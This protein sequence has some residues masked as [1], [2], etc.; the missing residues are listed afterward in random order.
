[1]R[2]T[3]ETSAPK[4]ESVPEKSRERHGLVQHAGPHLPVAI[5][6]ACC[7]GISCVNSHLQCV[8]MA[9]DMDAAS[10]PE[11]ANMEVDAQEAPVLPLLSL[12]VLQAIK[13]AQAQHGLRHNDYTRYRHV[14]QLC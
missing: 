3:S 14:E 8:T 11:P 4:S 10:A 5:D 2:Y 6:A 13:T 7:F 9:A 1:M 12:N